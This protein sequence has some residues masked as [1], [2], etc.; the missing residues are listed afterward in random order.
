MVG[1]AVSPHLAKISRARA[2]ADYCPRA[3][4]GIRRALQFFRPDSARI[5]VVLLLSIVSIAGGALKPWPLALLLDGV[6]GAS[7]LPRWFH[8]ANSSTADKA[9]L[10]ALTAGILFAIHAAQ[11]I[12]SAAQNF[13]AIQVGLCGLRRVRSQMFACLQRLSLRFHQ[14]SKVGD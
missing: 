8:A 7:P 2:G 13:V 5:A 12:L 10:I 1:S 4:N 6:L 9:A 3:M 11:G 14:N